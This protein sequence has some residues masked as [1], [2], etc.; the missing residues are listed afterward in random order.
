MGTFI[1][2]LLFG[3]LLFLIIRLSNKLKDVEDNITRLK[4]GVFYPDGTTKADGI[5]NTLNAYLSQTKKDIFNI[6][7]EANASNSL[8]TELKE[9]YAVLLGSLPDFES[10]K[11]AVEDRF[12]S[13]DKRQREHTSA[14]LEVKDAIKSLPVYATIEDVNK[15]AEAY[16]NK[17]IEEVKAATTTT[18]TKQTAP[19]K[20]TRNQKRK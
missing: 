13:V 15:A 1:A 10:Y 2:I 3:I 20:N 16:A 7:T 18:A 14:I 11:K 8:Y 9:K 12:N 4:Q 19:I 17:P 5:L 6:R